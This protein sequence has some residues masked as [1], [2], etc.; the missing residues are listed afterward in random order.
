MLEQDKKKLNK[1][2]WDNYSGDINLLLELY[3]RRKK[4]KAAIMI[5]NDHYVDIRD[6]TNMIEKTYV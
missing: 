1:F 4:A 2:K 5:G 3:F 6:E